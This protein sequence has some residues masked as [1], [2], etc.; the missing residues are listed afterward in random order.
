[1]HGKIRD[2]KIVKGMTRWREENERGC[3][4]R[5]DIFEPN[6]NKINYRRTRSVL[7]HRGDTRGMHVPNQH[8]KIA[9]RF[10]ACRY[11]ITLITMCRD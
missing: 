7:E 5:C 4:M 8:V 11:T 9:S 6:M 3:K 1:M 2:M 10:S